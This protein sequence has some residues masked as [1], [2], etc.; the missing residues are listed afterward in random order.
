MSSEFVDIDGIRLEYARVPAASSGV[1]PLVL[2][3]E[4]L[5]SV[6][7]WRDF[8]A[9]L[10]TATGAETLVYSRHGYG[11]SAPLTAKR[12][13]DYM[14]DEA[15]NVLPHLLERLGM[16][17]PVLIG[18]SDGASIVAIYG[19]SGLPAA[20]IVLM[21]PHVFVEDVSIT[22]IAAARDAFRTTDL[23]K[24]LGRYHDDVESAFWGW[25]DIWLDP[26]FRSWNIE[27]LVP[28]ITAPL[29]LIQGEGDEYGTPAQV[30]TIRRLAKTRCE[31]ALL[32]NCGH[33][34]HRDQ[35]EKTLEL[36]AGFVKS[37]MP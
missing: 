21:A 6:A 31:L 32:P 5:G 16:T 26:A 34:P 15:Q 25:N 10:A 3:H 36:I 22:S 28:K 24:R 19:G 27:G 1:P 8:P 2:L 7:M 13:V 20:G 14:H 29:L 17:R 37:L 4:G 35:P 18:H 11:R 9:R 23:P 30:E 12:K 33:S